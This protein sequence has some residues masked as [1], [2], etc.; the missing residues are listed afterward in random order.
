MHALWVTTPA[1]SV[2][3]LVLRRWVAQL[4]SRPLVER[5][6]REASVLRALRQHGYAL[7]P[8]LIAAHASGIE[9]GGTPALLMTRLPGRLVLSP[10]E[11]TLWLRQ[12]AR[13]LA[14][15]HALQIDA[16]PY[17]PWFGPA[18]L[19]P[20]PWAKEQAA[21]AEAARIVGAGLPSQ[22]AA[23]LHRDYQHFN[24]LWTGQRLTGVVDWAEA[25]A[26]PP[27]VDVAHCRWNLAVLFSV[28]MAEAFRLMYEAESGNAT[29]PRFDLATLVGYGPG[30]KL[31]IVGQVAGR[32]P[33]D[34]NG[35]DAR[36]DELLLAV[37]R[38]C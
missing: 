16:P 18:D 8:E 4:D 26:G 11:P 38:R 15:I 17:E 10:K 37:L 33:I 28:G 7:G 20:K 12:M 21:W 14:R 34:I 1:G 3:E 36:V 23:F 25:S 24:L 30:S 9:T 19:G 32:R 13:E 29:D 22:P 5:V 27:S 35:M 6:E 2:I 31:G